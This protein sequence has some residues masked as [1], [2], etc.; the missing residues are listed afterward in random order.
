M[1]RKFDKY[2][3]SA[4]LL[5]FIHVLF[6]YYLYLDGKEAK[7]EVDLKLGGVYTILAD[8]QEDSVDYVSAF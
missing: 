2:V 3:S 6:R 5:D 8:V 7:K 1:E 4:I